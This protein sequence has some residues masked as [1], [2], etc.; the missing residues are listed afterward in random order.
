MVVARSSSDFAPNFKAMVIAREPAAKIGEIREVRGHLSKCIF[1]ISA[2]KRGSFRKG[3]KMRSIL[4]QHN[5]W[6]CAEYAC[7][8]GAGRAATLAPIG[9]HNPAI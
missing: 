1:F 2:M 6:E 8:R 5:G 3:S 4:S 9:S 7:S